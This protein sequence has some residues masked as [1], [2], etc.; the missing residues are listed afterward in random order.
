MLL[1]ASEDSLRLRVDECVDIILQHGHEGQGASAQSGAGASAGGS[2][3]TVA[4]VQVSGAQAAQ[5]AS[6]ALQPGGSAAAPSAENP[7]LPDLDVFNLSGSSVHAG[8]KSKTPAK[9]SS[10]GEN[11]TAQTEDDSAD[12]MPLFYT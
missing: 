8:E 10:A 4:A 12:D 5:A 2:G 9:K 6:A 3:G 7:M 1:L 11:T